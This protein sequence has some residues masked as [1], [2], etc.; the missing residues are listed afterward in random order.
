MQLSKF[1]NQNQPS[2]NARWVINQKYKS[3]CEGAYLSYRESEIKQGEKLLSTFPNHK[4]KLEN[5]G[6]RN[7]TTKKYHEF[8]ELDDENTHFEN[9]M[10]FYS[11]LKE[12]GNKFIQ[13]L[14]NF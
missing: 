12:N 14:F 2:F 13:E 7:V 11:L 6:I 1:S 3:A 4:L 9:L 5:N 10:Y 8:P